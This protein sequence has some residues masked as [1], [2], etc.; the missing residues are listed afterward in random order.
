MLDGG[1]AKPEGAGLQHFFAGS[2]DH[3]DTVSLCRVFS[4]TGG[5]SSGSKSKELWPESVNEESLKSEFINPTKGQSEC[6]FCHLIK[7]GRENAEA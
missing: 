6:V 4:I 2:G 7:R 1:W 5:L 3:V